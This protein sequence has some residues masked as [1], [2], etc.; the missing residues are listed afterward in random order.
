MGVVI[1]ICVKYPRQG[2]SQCQ[3]VRSGPDPPGVLWLGWA[4]LAKTV[5]KPQYRG[6]DFDP[7]MIFCACSMKNAPAA[8]GMLPDNF[9]AN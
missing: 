8:S 9:R 2:A 1:E 4:Y 6:A 7:P 5:R 3:W